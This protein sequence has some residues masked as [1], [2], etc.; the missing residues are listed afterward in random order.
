M[1]YSLT[2][3]LMHLVKRSRKLATA[4]AWQKCLEFQGKKPFVIL[5]AQVYALSSISFSFDP[6]LW[7]PLLLSTVTLKGHARFHTLYHASH[8]S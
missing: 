4:T 1:L 8:I 5:N 6:S 3:S 2:H 7:W